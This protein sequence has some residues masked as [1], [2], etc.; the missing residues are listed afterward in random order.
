MAIRIIG[1]GTV[2]HQRLQLSH[3]EPLTRFLLTASLV[4]DDLSQ[5]TDALLILLTADVVVCQRIIPVFYCSIVHGVTPLLHYHI[6][7]II[8]P[9][10][11][12][13]TL[14]QPSA[15]QT[16]DGWLGLIQAT[17]I[18]ECGGGLLKLAFLKL[19]LS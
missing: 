4:L 1:G 13:I 5:I 15:R 7:C 18:A 17:H 10:Q 2:A 11:L 16:I 14:C 6:F 12:G 19:R 3:Q 8:K 9:V